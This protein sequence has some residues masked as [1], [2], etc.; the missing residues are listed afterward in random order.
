MYIKRYTSYIHCDV[1]LLNV[2]IIQTKLFDTFIGKYK[3]IYIWK[4]MRTR[5]VKKMELKTCTF[6]HILYKLLILF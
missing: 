1:A 6:V 4:I 2:F 5:T 3:T